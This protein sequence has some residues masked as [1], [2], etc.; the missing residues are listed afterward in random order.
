M[1][2][3]LRPTSAS[4]KPSGQFTI[5]AAMPMINRTGGCAPSPRSSYARSMRDA[6]TPRAIC[7]FS[8]FV[9]PLCELPKSSAS[10]SI[11]HARRYLICVMVRRAL[12]RALLVALGA[13]A[14][15][16]SSNQDDRNAGDAAA[17]DAAT[18]D[19]ATTDAATTD[20]ATTDAAELDATELDAGATDADA[21]AAAVETRVFVTSLKYDGNLGGLA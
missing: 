18:T 9:P 20:A 5:C 11:F 6:P 15:A 16:C 14:A 17:T 13:G 21:G 7:S 19:A 4:R 8:I 2:R 12:T 3:N 1:T 10:R